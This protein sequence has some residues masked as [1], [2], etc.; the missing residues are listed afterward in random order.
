MNPRLSRQCDGMYDPKFARMQQ[1]FRGTGATAPRA[2]L[3]L[4]S[5]SQHVDRRRATEANEQTRKRSSERPKTSDE[6]LVS[7]NEF[8]G[9]D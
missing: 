7:S 2:E 9:V 1:L 3:E 6:R 5:R 4:G 8:M